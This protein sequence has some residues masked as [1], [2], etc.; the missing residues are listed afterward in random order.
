MTVASILQCSSL[1]H[2]GKKLLYHP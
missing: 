1:S 2:V